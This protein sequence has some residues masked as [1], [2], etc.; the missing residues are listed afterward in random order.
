MPIG[1]TGVSAGQPAARHV[2]VTASMS[3]PLHFTGLSF[4][5]AGRADGDVVYRQNTG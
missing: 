5:A 3:A 1:R 4:A 2:G